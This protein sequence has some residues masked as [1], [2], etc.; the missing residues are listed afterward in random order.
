MCAALLVFPARP[1]PLRK[2]GGTLATAQLRGRTTF[3]TP[4][5]ANDPSVIGSDGLH[6]SRP[7]VAGAIP[8]GCAR[9]SR[10]QALIDPF[11]LWRLLVRCV[12]KPA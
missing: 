9:N 1:V 2:D 3:A 10:V 6:P 4:C 11:Q 5:W 12:E 8:R 7:R